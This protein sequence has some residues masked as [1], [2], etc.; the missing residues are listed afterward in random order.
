MKSIKYDNEKLLGGPSEERKRE[1]R[2]AIKQ[3]NIKQS[4]KKSN[5]EDELEELVDLDVNQL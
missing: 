5:E 2:E 3:E 1:I 4:R